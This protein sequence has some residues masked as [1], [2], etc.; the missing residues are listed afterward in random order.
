MTGRRGAVILV[1][2][3]A[4]EAVGAEVDGVA[5][6]FGF[7]ATIALVAGTVALPLVAPPPVRGVSVFLLAAFVASPAEAPAGCAFDEG[8]CFLLP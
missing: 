1:E 8:L 3:S 6:S 7:A 5:S 4:F 2:D